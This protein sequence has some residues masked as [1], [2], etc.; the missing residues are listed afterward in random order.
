MAGTL[1]FSK[2]KDLYI[3][4]YIYYSI[5]AGFFNSTGISLM[6]LYWN[7]PILLKLLSM[8]EHKFALQN[9]ELNPVE[10]WDVKSVILLNLKS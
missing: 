5:C 2:L 9:R 1:S 4:I 10:I 6:K 7:P 8:R 3:H